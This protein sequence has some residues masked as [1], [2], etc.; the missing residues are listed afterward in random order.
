[1]DNRYDNSLRE[2]NQ[3]ILD[4]TP[5]NVTLRVMLACEFRER[6]KGKAEYRVIELGSGEGDLTAYLFKVIPDIALEVLDVSPE[7]ISSA[8]VRL[9]EYGNRVTY[10]A[11]DANDYLKSVGD[12]AYDFILS[13]WTIHNFTWEDKKKLFVQIFSSLKPGGMM[14]LMDKI[15]AD[16][17]KEAQVSYGMQIARYKKL[18]DLVRDDM[19]AHEVQDFSDDY[20]MSETQTREVLET[21]GFKDFKIID[22]VGRDVV[23]AVTK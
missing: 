14:L 23:I 17:P 5:G 21:I 19:L 3:M 4:L 6:I 8:K 15:Y 10:I 12:T 22:R 9:A 16:D 11:N 13:A 18:G 20:R 1:M 7:M 2:A